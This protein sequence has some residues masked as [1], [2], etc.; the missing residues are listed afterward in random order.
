MPA[1]Y[2]SLK[3]NTVYSVVLNVKLFTSFVWAQSL[4]PMQTLPI[5]TS[6]GWTESDVGYTPKWMTLDEASK[7][8]SILKHCGCKKGCKSRCLCKSVDLPCIELCKCF[9][10]CSR[11]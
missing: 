9:G 1:G 4:V 5:A 6:W 8:L 2:L 11:D 10:Q 3:L 7:V